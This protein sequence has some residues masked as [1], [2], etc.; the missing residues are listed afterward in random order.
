M[1]EDDDYDDTMWGEE[2]EIEG[3]YHL[4]PREVSFMRA[5]A[6]RTWCE[7]GIEKWQVIPHYVAEALKAEVKGQGLT[8]NEAVHDAMKNVEYG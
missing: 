6:L 7:D 5:Y 1:N 4:T 8:I 3:H 2:D